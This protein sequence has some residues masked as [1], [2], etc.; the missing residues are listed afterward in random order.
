MRDELE[1]IA[2][3]WISL[4]TAPVNWELFDALHSDDFFDGSSAGREHS[5]KAFATA[6]SKFIHAFPDLAA[7]I[8][9]LVIDESTAKV[10]VRW[11]ATGTNIEK[12]LGIGPTHR[13]ITIRGI[14]IIEIVRGKIQKRWGEWDISEHHE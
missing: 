11:S 14:E 12:Y 9:D 13:K 8:D 2:R 1:S 5:K 6:L 7:T 4:W 3:Q 10:S